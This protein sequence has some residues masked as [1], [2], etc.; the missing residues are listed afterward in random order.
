MRFE[1]WSKMR[2]VLGMPFKEVDDGCGINQEKSLV[3][4]IVDSYRSHSSR[5]L[6]TVWEL[7]LPHNPRPVPAKGSNGSWRTAES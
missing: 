4:Q 1:Q 5:S 6:S 3:R 7:S 2:A